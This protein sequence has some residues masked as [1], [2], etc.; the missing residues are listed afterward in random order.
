MKL[1]VFALKNVIVGYWNPPT[2]SPQD[3]DSVKTTLIR[4][5]RQSTVEAKK[6]HYDECQL[7]YL[8]EFDDIKGKLILLDDPE[9][10]CDLQGEFRNE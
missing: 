8:G 5:C 3:K 10:L 6:A 9:Y 1:Q 7:F 4:F 2:F